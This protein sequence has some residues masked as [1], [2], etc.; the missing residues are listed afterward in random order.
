MFSFCQWFGKKC[1]MSQTHFVVDQKSKKIESDSRVDYI[2]N[3]EAVIKKK[4]VCHDF[5]LVN[6]NSQQE[7]MFKIFF[8]L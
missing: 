6:M 3:I 7:Q 5:Q 2:L 4:K 8:L 1:F